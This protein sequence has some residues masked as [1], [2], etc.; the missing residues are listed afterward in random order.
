M[1]WLPLCSS[2]P[3]GSFPEPH[4]NPLSIHQ[5]QSCRR[6]QAR[7]PDVP[8]PFRPNNVASVPGRYLSWSSWSSQE[9]SVF[10]STTEKGPIL[11]GSFP[12]MRGVGEQGESEW[13]SVRTEGGRARGRGDWE[14]VEGSS[15]VCHSITYRELSWRAELILTWPHSAI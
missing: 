5:V 2:W 13:G 3:L 15:G 11:G 4:P 9:M 1:R 6:C 8:M 14:K 7:G 10:L 12:S